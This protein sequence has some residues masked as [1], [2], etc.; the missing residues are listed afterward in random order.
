MVP[1]GVKTLPGGDKDT[2]SLLID[3][4]EDKG[5]GDSWDCFDECM[6]VDVVLADGH[7]VKMMREKQLCRAG[8]EIALPS[9]GYLNFLPRTYMGIHGS[10]FLLEEIFNGLGVM[11]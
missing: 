5:F 9:S 7:N 1:A 6:P 3:F 8:V 4:L 11:P 2:E 10:L